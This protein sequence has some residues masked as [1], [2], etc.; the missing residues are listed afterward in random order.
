MLIPKRVIFVVLLL[1]SLTSQVEAYPDD[2]FGV[3]QMRVNSVREP[4]GL[5]WYLK[6]RE[7]KAI[8]STIASFMGIDPRYVSLATDAIPQVSVVGEDT[9]Y[10]LPVPAGY[11]F[12]AARIVIHSIVPGSGDRPSEI[13][14]GIRQD[15]TALGVY[16]WTPI[17]HYGEGRTWIDAD[18]QV[19]GIKPNYL[20]EFRNKGVC[21]EP[22][23][24]NP[25]DVILRCKGHCSGVD[26]G[27]IDSA[28][29]TT[30]EI[31]NG[32]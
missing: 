28:G 7:A 11:A 23:S 15:G 9:F 6:T 13:S 8:L 31:A 14:A 5:D 25:D 24:N 20:Q 32:F 3:T 12:C 19:T 22:T 27:R 29:T 10:H 30:G 16:T 26:W 2:L 18:V 4:H 21:K 1:V 17:R